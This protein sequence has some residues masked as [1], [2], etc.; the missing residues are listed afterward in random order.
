MDDVHERW[1]IEASGDSTLVVTQ[2]E[3]GMKVGAAGALL[4][5]SLVRF[6]VRREMR[7]GLRGLKE[8]LERRASAARSAA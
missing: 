7:S 6:I 5:W 4:D 2:V 1:R 8:Y 3:Y